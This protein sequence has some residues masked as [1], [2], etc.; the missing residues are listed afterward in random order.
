MHHLPPHSLIAAR[1]TLDSRIVEG[2]RSVRV[3]DDVDVD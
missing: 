1:F 3:D 2:E